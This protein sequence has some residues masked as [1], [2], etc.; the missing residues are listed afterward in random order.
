MAE[1]ALAHEADFPLA[2]C[3]RCARDVLTHVR[4]DGEGR[5]G[6]ACVHCDAALDPAEIRWVDAAALDR[7]GYAVLGEPGG[8]CGRPGCGQGR[9]GSRPA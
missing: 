8:G 1:A 9:C 4:L 2:H 3:A 6:R 7:A 5:E